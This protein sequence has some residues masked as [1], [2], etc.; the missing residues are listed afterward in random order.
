M[1]AHP[2]TPDVAARI[3]ERCTALTR[4]N[5]LEW[6]TN[7][8]TEFWTELPRFQV[9]VWSIPGTGSAPH[10]FQLRDIST[11]HL[12]IEVSTPDLD[13]ETADHIALLYGAARHNALG[14]ADLS[15]RLLEDLDA[16]E[17]RLSV[18]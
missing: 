9:I 10:G 8:E 3:V 13:V 16:V 5:A 7:S 15:I 18:A 4:S 17:Q 2:L 6:G 11:G 1:D 14:L 12:M